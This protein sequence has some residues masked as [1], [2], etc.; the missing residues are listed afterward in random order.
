VAVW[1]FR[2]VGWPARERREH[3]SVLET[4]T[5]QR[6]KGRVGMT[7]TTEAGAGRRDYRIASPLIA[8]IAE[9]LA[10]SCGYQMGEDEILAA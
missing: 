4:Y 7:S 3:F 8:L 5:I 1:G 10:T 2:L 6:T 9:V